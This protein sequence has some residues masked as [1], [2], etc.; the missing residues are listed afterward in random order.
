M[1]GNG[2]LAYSPALHLLRESGTTIG[3]LDLLDE[4]K[5]RP[6]EAAVLAGLLLDGGDEALPDW[7]YE[8][9]E[10]VNALASRSMRAGTA[11]DARRRKLVPIVDATALK[12]AMRNGRHGGFR[13]FLTVL[14]LLALLLAVLSHYQD[15]ELRRSRSRVT[16]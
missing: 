10:F 14:S 5:L 15:Y 16:W 3:L 2:W 12:H 6:G 4:R 13:G 9:A 7:Q 1:A 11:F 8:Q